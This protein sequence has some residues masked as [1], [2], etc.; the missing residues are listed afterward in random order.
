MDQLIDKT[1][2]DGLDADAEDGD[3]EVDGEVD[4]E[5]N[6]G[7]DEN[8]D[9]IGNDIDEDYKFLLENNGLDD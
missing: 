7:D 5:N 2:L 6:G 3:G 1:G 9:D 8:M 4:G